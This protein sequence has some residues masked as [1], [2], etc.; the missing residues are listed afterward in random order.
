MRQITGVGQT[1]EN[2]I[3]REARVVRHQFS[4]GL[5]G[6][7]QFEDEFDSQSRTADHRLSRQ[8]FGIYDDSFGQR[9]YFSLSRESGVRADAIS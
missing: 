7:E 3:A 2:V 9:H 6:G 4:F 1:R 5:S 8:D